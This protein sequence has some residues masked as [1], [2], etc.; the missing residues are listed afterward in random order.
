[1]NL[2]F[3]EA[4][5]ARVRDWL[6]AAFAIAPAVFTED[7]MIE[8]LRSNEWILLTTDNGA[9]VLQFFHDGEDWAANV[10]VVG[11]KIGGSLRELMA[12]Q[13]QVCDALRKMGFSY[14]QGEPRARWTRILLKSGWQQHER[15]F[16]KRLN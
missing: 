1:M 12:L 7:E 2:K 6:L 15:I 14:I 9:A 4:E 5:Y 10:I 11:G 3:D 8:K 13:E 16:S